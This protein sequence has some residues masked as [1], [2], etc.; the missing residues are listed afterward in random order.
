ML[1]ITAPGLVLK[2]EDLKSPAN[3]T[4]RDELKLEVLSS[5]ASD[6]ARDE[7]HNLQVC[8]YQSKCMIPGAGSSTG[9][10]SLVATLQ[11]LSIAVI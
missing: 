5:P 9:E 11:L 6:T 8:H 1:L 10:K 4:A 7:F 2:Q 3:D